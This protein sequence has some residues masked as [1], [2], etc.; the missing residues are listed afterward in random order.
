MNCKCCDGREFRL[1]SLVRRVLET[2]AAFT[3]ETSSNRGYPLVACHIITG[4]S[5]TGK[6]S[7]I[8]CLKGHGFK[9]VEEPIRQILAEQLEIDGPALPAKDPLLF[10]ELALKRCAADHTK[11]N[12]SDR[13]VFFDRGIPDLIAYAARF[14][15]NEIP[16][17]DSSA[18]HKY[19]S[20]VFV[21]PP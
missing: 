5:G 17:Q 20:K 7:L 4:T 1:N 15:V 12:S 16:F 8:D 14:G 18:E 3:L 21:L 2:L 13:P 11:W 19:G 9:T 6:T 10:L